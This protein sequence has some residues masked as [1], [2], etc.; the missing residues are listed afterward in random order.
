MDVFKAQQTLRVCGNKHAASFITISV[1][2][3]SMSKFQPTDLALSTPLKIDL[4]KEGFTT[5]NG[6]PRM[7]EKHD[8]SC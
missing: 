1:A 7:P 5:M 3:N 4:R 2:A 6:M 8:D